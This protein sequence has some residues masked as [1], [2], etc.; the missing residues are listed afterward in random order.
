MIATYINQHRNNTLCQTFHELALETWATLYQ[1]FTVS[2]T[3]GEETITDNNLFAIQSL[4]PNQVAIVK[5]SR[6]KESQIGADWEWWLGNPSD[7]WVKMRIQAKKIIPRQLAYKGVD[8]PDGTQ[9]QITNLISK[10]KSDGY[11][12]AYCLYNTNLNP[13]TPMWGCA[14]AD[15]DAMLATLK[16]SGKSKLVDF[17]KIQ[18]AAFPWEKL[19]C[20]KDTRT[21]LPRRVL[22]QFANIIPEN[23]RGFLNNAYSSELPEHITTMLEPFFTGRTE[24]IETVG[25]FVDEPTSKYL[26]IISDQSIFERRNNNFLNE[27]K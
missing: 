13:R 23:R 22:N 18:S 11:I 1:S 20:E 3:V 14:I 26:A 9:L 2:M 19:V 21:S 17:A 24:F 5:F 10:S 15:A 25:D 4:H 8:H 7:G 27:E 16:A 6:A 12:P